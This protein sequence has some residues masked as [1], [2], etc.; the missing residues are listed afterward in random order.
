[1]LCYLIRPSDMTAEEMATPEC[2]KRIKVQVRGSCL[3]AD[4]GEN[5][6]LFFGFIWVLHTWL[7]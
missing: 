4:P 7:Q 5:C 3:F 2:M 6:A 1:M